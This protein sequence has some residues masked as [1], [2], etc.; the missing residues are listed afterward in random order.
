MKTNIALFFILGMMLVGVYLDQEVYEKE[1]ARAELVEKSLFRQTDFKY[2]EFSNGSLIKREGTWGHSEIGWSLNSLKV[3]EFIKI[4][5]SL[6]IKKK[7][8]EFN[9]ED[10]FKKRK[11]IF[12]VR[13]QKSEHEIWFGDSIEATG[14]FYVYHVGLKELYICEDTSH[15]KIPYS[16]ARDYGLKK[17]L[18]LIQLLERGVDL[19][20]ESDFIEGLKMTEL[21]RLNIDSVRNRVLE[22]DLVS[23]KTIPQ[24]PTPLEYRDLRKTVLD[25]FQKIQVLRVIASGQNY[26]SD[27]RS[28]L[29]IEGNQNFSLRYFSGLNEKFGKYIRIEGLDYIFEVEMEPR[30]IFFLSGNDFWLKNFHY[31]QSLSNLSTLEFSLAFGDENWKDFSIFDLENFKVKS[32]SNKV[33]FSQVHINVLFNLLLNLV[34]FKEAVYVEKVGVNQI[35]QND[36]LSV[37]LLG[38]VMKV[39]VEEDFI[40]VIDTEYNLLYHFPDVG[41]QIKPGFFRSAFTVETN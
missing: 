38:K 5:H 20:W 21:N 27:Q 22:I 29:K 1:E 26:L 15:Y 18:R 32:L 11:H 9:L 24:A 10:F 39:W 2:F 12:K 31:S 25:Y 36:V 17:Y 40:K 41:D 3:N 19:F 6:Q 34:D 8:M 35:P 7:L 30:N 16:S 37:K 33:S 14:R 28:V 4:L 13:D 23:G